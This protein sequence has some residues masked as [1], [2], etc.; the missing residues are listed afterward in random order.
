MIR[1]TLEAH[2]HEKTGLKVYEFG[3]ATGLSV[4]LIRKWWNTNRLALKLLISGY[5]R[6]VLRKEVQP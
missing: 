5:E 1:P 3:K 2:I 6:E 4:T